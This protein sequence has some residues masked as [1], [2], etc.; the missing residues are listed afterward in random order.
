[1]VDPSRGVLYPTRLP[2]FTRLPPPPVAA[3]LVEW[4]W[5][6]EWNLAPGRSSRQE[7]VGY[8]ASHLVVEPAAVGLAG[9]TTRRSHRDLTGRG[10][11]VG[12]HLRPAAVAALVP[13]PAATVDAYVPQDQPELHTAVVAAMARSPAAARHAA[14][15][16]AFSAWLIE[17]IPVVDA[18]GRLANAMAELLIADAAI[19][20]VADAAERLSVSVRTLQRVARTHVGVSPAAMIRRRRLQE[21]AQRLR[22]DPGADLADVAAELGYA[23]HAHLT[24][25]FRAVLGFTP[26]RYRAA[27]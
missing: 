7:I 17:R 24:H 13:D 6:P 16:H 26:S 21:A 10:W 25:D 18:H 8:P 2:T 22:D 4:F 1:M 9:P 15:V 3:E 23:D 20:R 11:A 14:V 19:L 27:V 12:A 5:I